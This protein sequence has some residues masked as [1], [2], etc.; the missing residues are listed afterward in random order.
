MPLSYDLPVQRDALCQGELIRSIYEPG[1][2]S[3]PTADGTQ[4]EFLPTPHPLA[5][6]VGPACDLAQDF[7]ARFPDEEHKQ[8]LLSPEYITKPRHIAPHI[9]FCDVFEGDEIRNPAPIPDRRTWDLMQKN[10][11]QRYHRFE[12]AP[13][14]GGK[15]M[16]ELFLDFKKIFTLPTGAIYEALR[17]ARIQR[18]AVVPSIY[19][20]DLIHRFYSFQSRIGLPD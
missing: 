4:I 17:T 6:I 16:P 12:S 8:S 20:H 1:A 5:I 18:E 11:H 15:V 9:L 13:I 2:T 7:A 3:L 19:V 14:E 10:Q